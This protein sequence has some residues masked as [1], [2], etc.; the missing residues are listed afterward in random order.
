M[1]RVSSFDDLDVY[2]RAYE[3]SLEIHR[4]SLTFP[5]IEQ[6]VLADQMRRASKSIC[7]NIAEGFGKQRQSRAEYKR[8]LLMA[9][10]SADEMQV[11]TRY[12]RDLGYVDP[13][14]AQRW[15][16]E[17][18]SIARMLQG[19]YSAWANPDV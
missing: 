19:L 12:C 13:E 11:W 6:A 8:F 15:M 4:M 17:Y 7:A 9:V 18:K 16:D 1:N 14:S 5:K 2:K 3:V 10:G